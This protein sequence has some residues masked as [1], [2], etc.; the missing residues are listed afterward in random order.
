MCTQGGCEIQ[1]FIL[2]AAH[3]CECM[4]LLIATCIS[5]MIY[6]STLNLG[7]GRLWWAFMANDEIKHES[8]NDHHHQNQTLCSTQQQI[9]AILE[10]TGWGYATKILIWP[11]NIEIGHYIR[12]NLTPGQV[13][14]RKVFL[15]IFSQYLRLGCF[16][17]SLRSRKISQTTCQFYKNNK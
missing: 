5:L 8:Q 11:E 7:A 4:W 12:W 16:L 14:N 9:S 6:V 2:Q 1:T 3:A 15:Q 10:D 13:P 17:S